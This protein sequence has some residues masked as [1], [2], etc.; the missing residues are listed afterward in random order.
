MPAPDV[1]AARPSG[2]SVDSAVIQQLLMPALRDLVLCLGPHV[3]DLRGGAVLLHRRKHRSA[4]A[5][6]ASRID[7]R[8]RPVRPMA[9]SR[10]E[11]ASLP[12]GLSFRRVIEK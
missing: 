3:P 1:P 10:Y 9:A 2:S 11:L 4:L 7:R 12:D 8:C 5:A 6:T